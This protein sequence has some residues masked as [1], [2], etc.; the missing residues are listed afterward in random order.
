[1]SKLAQRQEEVIRA[2][3]CRALDSVVKECGGKTALGARFGVSYQAVQHWFKSGVPYQHCA[4]METLT[5]GRVQCEQLRYDYARLD[6]RP[7]RLLSN[8]YRTGD[9]PRIYIAGPMTGYPQLNHA[10][11]HA[12]AARLRAAGLN[13]ISP[14]EIK[15]SGTPT[16]NDF[17]RAD[18]VQMMKCS[19]VCLLPGWENSPGAQLEHQIATTIDNFTFMLAGDGV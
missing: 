8:I 11:F 5:L 4:V 19:A 2:Q 16:L 18:I 10:A 7:Y 3:E 1:M 14:A 9:K 13:V 15:L 17:M 6:Q 12:E